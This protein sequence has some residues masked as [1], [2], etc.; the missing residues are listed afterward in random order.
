MSVPLGVVRFK[1]WGERGRLTLTADGQPVPI[2]APDRPDVD[3]G[4]S[5]R[6][7]VIAHQRQRVTVVGKVVQAKARRGRIAQRPPSSHWSGAGL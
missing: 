7:H 2:R 3:A 1:R 5:S 4:A 6:A